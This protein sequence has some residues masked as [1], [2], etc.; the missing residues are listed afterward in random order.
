MRCTAQ[1]AG[2]GGGGRTQLHSVHWDGNHFIS[3]FRRKVVPR[4]TCIPDLLHQESYFYAFFTF[5]IHKNFDF[6][7]FCLPFLFGIILLVAK[8]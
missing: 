5:V 8:L 1:G 6:K 3:S 4:Q 7:N 2:G